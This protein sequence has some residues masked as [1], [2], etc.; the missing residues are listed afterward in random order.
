MEF[1]KKYDF[2]KRLEEAERIIDK[3]TDRI[4]IIV[5]KHSKC[6]N[7]E[8]IN[9]TKYLVPNSITMG[10][11]THIIRKRLSISAATALFVFVGGIIPPTSTTLDE[12]YEKYKDKDKF[13]YLTYSGENTFGDY[14]V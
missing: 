7:L 6:K 12:I 1:K 14:Y 9:R 8:N 10:Q 4:P 5:E 13:L 11:F 3:Y 2:K